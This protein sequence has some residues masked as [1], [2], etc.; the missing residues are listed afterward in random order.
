MKNKLVLPDR[1]K[2]VASLIPQCNVLADIG[3]DHAYIPIYTV[4]NGIAKTSIAADVVD[5]PLKIA[6]ENIST[7]MLSEKISVVKSDGLTNINN[8]DLIVIAGMGG[9]L[10][11]DIL[12][13]DLQKAKSADTLILQPMSCAFELRKRLHHFGFLIEKEVLVKDTGKIYAAMVV[14]KGKQQFENDIHYEIGKYLIDNKPP[15]FSDYINHKVS[16]YNKR[17]LNMENSKNIDVKAEIINLK[18][19]IEQLKG[20]I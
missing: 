8:A 15:L 14:K 2:A 3:T 4:L 18:S 6:K 5:G 16:V 11:A 10:I 20:L 9:T 19:T 17:I 7:Y 13:A 12:E 1:L